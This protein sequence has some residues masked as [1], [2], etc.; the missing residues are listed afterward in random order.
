MSKKAR[1]RLTEWWTKHW[2]KDARCTPDYKG[3]Q[4]YV[5]ARAILENGTDDTLNV[6]IHDAALVKG[7]LYGES[8]GGR[9]YPVG[10]ILSMPDETDN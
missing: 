7:E 4:N 1:A 3:A 9:F 2:D 8:P 5:G 10:R 6:V